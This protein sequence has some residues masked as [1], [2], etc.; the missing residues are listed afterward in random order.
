MSEKIVI[1]PLTRISGFLQIEV[2]VEKNIIIDAKSSGMMFRGF[3][4]MLRDRNP[5]DATYFTERICGICS[6]A[7]A[8]ASTM[9]LEKALEIKIN[10]DDKMMREFMHGCE[11]LQNHLRHFYQ[12]TLPDYIKDPLSK[13]DLSENIGNDYRLPKDLESKL[14]EHY[15][16]SLDFSRRAHQMLATLGGKVPHTHGIFTGGVTVDLDSSKYIQ[17][18]SMLTDIKRF[19]E[20]IMVPDVYVIADYYSDYFFNGAGYN[21][22]MS[23]G[24]FNS[25]LDKDIFYLDA[26][27]SIDNTRYRFYP[28]YISEGVYNSWYTQNYKNDSEVEDTVNIDYETGY[29]FIKVPRYNGYAME[30]GPLARMILSGIYNGGI[31]TMDRTIARVLEVQKVACILQG[32]LE[33]IKPIENVLPNY[34]F[35]KPVNSMGL[36]DTTRGTLG[37]WISIDENKIKNYSIISPST[38]NLSP[39]DENGVHG[40]VEKALIGTYIT[41][42]KNPVEIGRIV[43]SFDPCVSCATHVVSDKF[44]PFDVR[45]N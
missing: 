26:G 34:S 17:L 20:D 9:A 41:D 33:R 23:Y 15:I 39:R 5:L 31:S 25:F 42:V 4:K 22:L 12:Y 24:V 3:E 21:N 28:E 36:T 8:I 6:T 45:I 44:S 43:R 30:V 14:S 7:H 35:N 29:T 16:K 1:N 19:I 10:D 2:Q 40:V 38:W 18:K 32:L 11:F 13:G 27:V 37:H